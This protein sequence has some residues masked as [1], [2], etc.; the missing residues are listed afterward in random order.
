M[1]I[2]KQGSILFKDK[3]DREFNSF[4]V[5]YFDNGF[6][7]VMKNGKWALLNAKGEPLSNYVFS[8]IYDPGEEG[9]IPVSWKSESNYYGSYVDTLGKLQDKHIF[10]SAGFFHNG[11]AIVNYRYK[12]FSPKHFIIDKSF[13]VLF[14]QIKKVDQSLQNKDR[15]CSGGAGQ[16]VCLTSVDDN[17]NPFTLFAQV[18]EVTGN[19]LCKAKV[20]VTDIKS[21]TGTVV[22]NE[23]EFRRNDSRWINSVDSYYNWQ[24]CE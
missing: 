20:L 14:P 8:S 10:F 15:L 7:K 9:F 3:L 1:L 16:R 2:N 13:N 22:L 18:E 4:Q 17:F 19:S 21:K 11:Y 5:S 24:L 12:T 6:Y 23:M